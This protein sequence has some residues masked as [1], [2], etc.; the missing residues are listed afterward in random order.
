MHPNK[1]EAATLA[2]AV[3][4]CAD[5][6]DP[7]ER[8]AMVQAVLQAEA[9]R[10]AVERAAEHRIQALRYLWQVSAISLT[11]VIGGLLLVGYIQTQEGFITGCVTVA[12]GGLLSG[13]ILSLLSG[14]KVEVKDVSSG[15][16]GVLTANL[17]SREKTAPSPNNEGG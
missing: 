11:L 2:V 10:I 17:S 15:V 1:S 12:L 9:E 3:A 6:K 16:L 7:A 5:I 13:Y 4:A 8:V 14:S